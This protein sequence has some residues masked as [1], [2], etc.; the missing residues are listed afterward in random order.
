MNYK[1]KLLCFLKKCL[2]MNEP[3]IDNNSEKINTIKNTDTM[4]REEYRYRTLK[5]TEYETFI[6]IKVASYFD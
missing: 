1:K 4:V 5:L 2:L 3:I 6:Y